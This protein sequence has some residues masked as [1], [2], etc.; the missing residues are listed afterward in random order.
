[1]TVDRSV[2]RKVLTTATIGGATFLVSNAFKQSI[3]WSIS[4]TLFMSGVALVVQFLAQFESHLKA[5]TSVFQL[6]EASALLRDPM[7]RLVRL[8]TQLEPTAPELLHDFARSE[9]I[10]VSEL[11][12][13]L[14]NGGD[15]TYDGEDHDW[16][17]ELTRNLK[18]SLDAT[19][20][21][22]ASPGG[23]GFVDD[24]L[25]TSDLG[26]RYLEAQRQVVQRGVRIRRIFVLDR[27]ELATEDDLVTLCKLQQSYGIMVRILTPADIPSTRHMS[28]FDFVLFDD[29]VSYELTSASPFEACPGTTILNTR[30]ELRRHRVQERIQRFRDLW[31]SAHEFER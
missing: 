7:I 11:M 18:S 29:V 21:R 12:Q 23:K 22:S 16:L 8:S 28:L 4:V 10:R 19:S 30:L 6:V 31:E 20:M 9:I 26:L 17:L 1:M 24:G 25:W 3:I 5:S 13:G 27:P 15:I 14:I 2:L